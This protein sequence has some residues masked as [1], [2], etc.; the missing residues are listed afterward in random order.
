MA[1]V[2][3]AR[4]EGEQWVVP[5][6]RPAFEAPLEQLVFKLDLGPQRWLPGERIHPRPDEQ[7]AAPEQL[8]K[9]IVETTPEDL[10]SLTFT[11]FQA[12]LYDCPYSPREV[13]RRIG[14]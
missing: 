14:G 1:R 7:R 3:F 9:V 12:G 2:W 5:G 11:T 13:A 10:R 6:G 4:R 8:Q